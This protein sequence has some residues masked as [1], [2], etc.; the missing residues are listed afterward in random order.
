MAVMA[1]KGKKKSK[2]SSPRRPAA[3]PRPTIQPT[4]RKP[5]FWRTRDGLMILG[6]LVLVGIG[7]VVWLIMGA[8]EAARE[9]EDRQEATRRYTDQIGNA[10]TAVNDPAE[11]LANL[12]ELPP[13]DEL[14]DAAAEAEEWQ[15]EFIG[16]QA[17]FQQLGANEDYAPI[18]QLFSEGLGLYANAATL[19]S[20]LDDYDLTREQQGELFSNFAAQRDLATAIFGSAIGAFDQLRDEIDMDPSRLQPPVPMNAPIVNPGAEQGDGDD[21]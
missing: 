12:R 14:G 11:G 18:N 21:G 5:S 7:V 20:R 4:R 15:T 19:L 13:Q 8:Q 6:V 17:L 2:G 9:L 1:I 16:A 10:L 3:A